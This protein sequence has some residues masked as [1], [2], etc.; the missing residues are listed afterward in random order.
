M[1]L[2]TSEDV[3][4]AREQATQAFGEAVEQARTPL[5]AVLGAT[6]LAAHALMETLNKAREQAESARAE[7]AN[8]PTELRKRLDSY[9]QSAVQIYDYLADRGEETLERLRTQPVVSS[10]EEDVEAVVDDVQD[11]GSDVLGKASQPKSESAGT[12]SS[13]TKGSSTAKGSST[14]KSSSTAKSAKSAKQSGQ[15]ST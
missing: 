3:N 10:V 11:L 15:R 8:D 7:F 1:T 5:L 2:P 13:T 6:D 14:T 4:K 9:A 12:K